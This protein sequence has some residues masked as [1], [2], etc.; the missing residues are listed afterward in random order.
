VFERFTD[1]ARQVVVGAQ[2]EAAALKHNY[3]GTEHILLG[4]L[5]VESGAAYELL[6]LF[7]VPVEAVQAR[8]EEIVGRGDAV[9]PATQLPFTPRAKKVLELA[10]RE[11]L[12]L[13][14]KY[15]GTEHF[16][17]GLL[18]EGEGVGAQVLSERGVTLQAVTNRLDDVERGSDR[19]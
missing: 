6:A 18:R 2:R 1:R 15:I 10:L 16:L 7:D 4:L 19:G 3:I 14:D 17:L 12:R 13:G 9:V 8:V 5:R 11:A